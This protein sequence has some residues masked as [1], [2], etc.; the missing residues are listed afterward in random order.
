MG[1]HLYISYKGLLFLTR[2]YIDTKTQKD[3]EQRVF[4]VNVAAG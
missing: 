4:K 3:A 1:P 2:A